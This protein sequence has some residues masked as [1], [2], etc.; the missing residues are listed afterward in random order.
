[1]MQIILSLQRGITI[2]SP[3]SYLVSASVISLS[4][5]ECTL[6]TNDPIIIDGLKLR[7]QKT[8]YGYGV[9]FNT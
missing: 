2:I 5:G 8:S 9:S 3:K 4:G 6:R 7:P 1:M